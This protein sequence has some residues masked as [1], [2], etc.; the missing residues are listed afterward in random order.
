MISP[1][2]LF[3]PPPAPHKKGYRVTK[4][5]PVFMFGEIYKQISLSIVPLLYKEFNSSLLFSASITA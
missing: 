1:T 3:H 4:K 5:V 2:D